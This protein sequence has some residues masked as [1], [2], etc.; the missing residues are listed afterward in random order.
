MGWALACW[1]LELFSQC[2]T[3]LDC[4]S[5]ANETET[6][7]SQARQPVP[8]CLAEGLCSNSIIFA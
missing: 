6:L 1:I 3:L 8:A 7:Y 4:Y 2:K 5:T